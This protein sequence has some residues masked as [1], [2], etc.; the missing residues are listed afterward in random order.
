ML[1]SPFAYTVFHQASHTHTR[2][3]HAHLNPLL[4]LGATALVAL[5]GSCSAG[6]CYHLLVATPTGNSLSCTMQG[7][8]EP[9]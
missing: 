3:D 1:D 7:T 8:Y 5:A 2:I 6:F 4:A 9:I